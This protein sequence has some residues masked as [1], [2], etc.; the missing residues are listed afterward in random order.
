VSRR[1]SPATADRN[2]WPEHAQGS[3]HYDVVMPGC[4]NMMDIQAAIG[5]HQLAARGSAD[6]P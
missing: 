3:P 2:A 1:E 4:H 5:I 6:P